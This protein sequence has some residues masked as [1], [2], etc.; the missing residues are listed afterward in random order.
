[1]TGGTLNNNNASVTSVNNIFCDTECYSNT[2]CLSYCNTGCA[3]ACSMGEWGPSCQNCSTCMNNGNCSRYINAQY[4]CTCTTG[5]DPSLD[6]SDCLP[7]YYG[8]ECINP[9]NPCGANMH[10][11]SGLSGNGHCICNLNFDV[12]S[13]CT[14]CINNFNLD[15]NCTDC[16][17]N[18]YGSDCSTLCTQTCYNGYCSAGINGNGT[19]ICKENYDPRTNC[20]FALNTG[21]TPAWEIPVIASSIVGAITI[22]AVL[23]TSYKLTHR[24]EK[25]FE[26]VVIQD[27][28]HTTSETSSTQPTSAFI[29]SSK[30]L[31]IN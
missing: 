20:L 21:T 30:P 12:N 29:E 1:V 11:L 28:V 3:Y 2:I 14:K 26:E 8:K 25:V 18:F 24:V 13:N 4:P 7:N 15:L 27:N 5:Y 9:C 23:Y 22:I 16:D 19:C 6:C 31:S 10:C 17:T